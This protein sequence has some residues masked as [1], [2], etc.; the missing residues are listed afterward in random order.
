MSTQIS[1][2]LVNHGNGRDQS[3]L[4]LADRKLVKISIIIQSR[5]PSV[6]GPFIHKS[7]DI[8]PRVQSSS[9]HGPDPP[10][11]PFESDHV[12]RMVLDVQS[13]APAER[14]VEPPAVD[15]E[16]A[17]DRDHQAAGLDLRAELMIDHL[18]KDRSARARP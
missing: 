1:L 17:A 11:G 8:P 12:I 2:G 13:Q 16:T 7:R 14:L 9:N 3:A 15:V 6:C 10:H 5:S 4:S 18:A